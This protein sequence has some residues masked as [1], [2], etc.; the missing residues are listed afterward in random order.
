MQGSAKVLVVLL[1][2]VDVLFVVMFL[3][4]LLLLDV[5]CCC[6]PSLPLLFACAQHML[7]NMIQYNGL[8]S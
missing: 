7:Y 4:F 1:L 6:A 3:H 8:N 5:L 2:L